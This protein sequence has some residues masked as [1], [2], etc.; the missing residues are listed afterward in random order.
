MPSEK[1]SPPPER[2]QCHST[3]ALPST[4]STGVPASHASITVREKLSIR[5]GWTYASAAAKASL[6]SSSETNPRSRILCSIPSGGVTRPAPIVRRSTE[7]LPCSQE[8]QNASTSQSQPL[9]SSRSAGVEQEGP[10]DVVARPETLRVVVRGRR[11][12]GT[13]D[14]VVLGYRPEAVGELVLGLGEEPHRAR[15]RED[16]ADDVEAGVASS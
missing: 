14:Q 1:L 13:C 9:S 12:P 6:R 4:A 3:T 8:T 5:L 11:H 10:L 7:S 15:R 2:R 16:V